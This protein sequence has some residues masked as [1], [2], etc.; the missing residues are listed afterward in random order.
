MRAIVCVSVWAC[1]FIS[2]VLAQEAETGAG[3]LSVASEAFGH[4]EM[5]PSKFTCQ[6]EDVNPALIIENVPDEA[7]SIALVMDDPDAPMG[8]WVHWVAYNIPAKEKIVIKEGESAG[9][10]GLND[11]GKTGY[12]GPCPPFGMHRYFFKVYA[13]DMTLELPPGST[14]QTLTEVMAGH[15]IDQGELIGRYKKKK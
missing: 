10:E 3:K 11:F 12:G 5:I 8:T 15:I 9:V 14:K 4:E 13:L 7:L 2:P 6:G 1:V